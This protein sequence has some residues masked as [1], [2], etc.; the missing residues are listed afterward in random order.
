MGLIQCDIPVWL[1]ESALQFIK[2]EVPDLAGIV[3]TGDNLQHNIWSQTED[4]SIWN[5]RHTSEMLKE[6]FGGIPVFPV[7]GNH[8]PVPVNEY[9]TEDK[10]NKLNLSIGNV[11]SDWLDGRALAQFNETGYYEMEMEMLPNTRLIGLNSQ[12]CNN[13]NYFFFRLH[14][15]PGHQLNWLESR[16]KAARVD[17]KGVWLV[18]HIPSGSVDC[19]SEWSIRFRALIDA[20]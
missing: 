13:L 6:H 18:S 17:K 20:F 12:A 11:W 9:D 5:T 15:D 3:W 19:F 4:E 10:H 8:E 14:T 2:K 16:L 1:G 7:L